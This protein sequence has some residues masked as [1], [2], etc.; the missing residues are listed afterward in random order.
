MIFMIVLKSADR[1]AKMQTKILFY[2]LIMT[3]FIKFDVCTCK[4]CMLLLKQNTNK[5]VGV[6]VDK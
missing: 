6:A 1:I 2:H 4:D 5:S 3:L